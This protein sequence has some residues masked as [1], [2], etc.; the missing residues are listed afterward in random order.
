MK[1]AFVRSVLG[2]LPARN[3]GVCYAH[4]HIILD[5]SYTTTR[6]LEFRLDSVAKAA[7][8]L[9]EFKKLGGCSMVDSMPCAVWRNAVK[10]A[11]V[12]RLSGVQILCPTGLHL[13]K[14]YP[15]G[16][17]GGRMSSDELARL[18]VTAAE[19]HCITG[20]PILTHTEQGTAAD[21][22]VDLLNRLGVSL[23]HVVISHTDRKPDLGYH[24]D[25]LSSGVCV[26]YDSAF[27]WSGDAGNPTL[28]LMIGL[29][30]GGLLGL[31]MLGMDAALVLEK[32][33]RGA[34]LAV[35]A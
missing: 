28:D 18:F 19:A 35:F 34:G 29:K 7:A 2:D 25:V 11:E 12:S 17:W 13:A 3:L 9:L 1:G 10:L 21:K 5:S 20:A 33:F 23:G 4:E 30:E 6:Y 32:L 16:H 24:K 14:Y 31:V 8:D 15:D 22:Q 27:R 26:E